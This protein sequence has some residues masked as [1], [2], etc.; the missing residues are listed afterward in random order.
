MPLKEKVKNIELNRM[1]NGYIINTL[2]SVDICEI[3]KIGGKVIQIDEGVLYRETFKVSP[4]RKVI[5]KLFASRQKYKEEH[6]D[7][8]EG[9]VKLIMN[10]L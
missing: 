6:N 3:V 9:L 7:L 2:T 1:R 4:F 10:S 5:V 8:M